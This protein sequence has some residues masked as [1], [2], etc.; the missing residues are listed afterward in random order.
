MPRISQAILDSTFYL[1][2]TEEDAAGGNNFGGTG[3]LVSYECVY[4]VDNGRLNN[5]VAKHHIYA[6][7]NWHVALRSG[8]SVIRINTRDGK[9]KTFPV[10]PIDWSFVPRGDDVAVTPLPVDFSELQCNTIGTHLFETKEY[11]D[12]RVGPGE[13]V[14]MVGRFVDHD[15]GTTNQPAIRFGNISVMPTAMKI[16]ELSRTRDYYCI[17]L[18]SRSG[19][20]GSPVFAYRT[21][22]QDL[23]GND[24]Q[25]LVNKITN[26]EH[27]FS[28]DFSPRLSLLGIHCGQFT[29]EWY[30][31]NRKR[32]SG[33]VKGNGEYIVGMSGMAIV[34]PA[35]TIMEALDLPKFQR[36][37]AE[38]DA[39][40]LASDLESNRDRP[41]LEASGATNH[42]AT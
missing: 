25:K 2:R 16:P 36:E 19:F 31:D 24:I 41:V 6:V 7:T 18:H 10:D 23:E 17:D 1:Y 28:S 34:S 39:E 38:V 12:Y 22:G 27:I 8:C 30:I 42:R 3:F 13:D 40:R 29:E 9:T 4:Q 26:M 11:L 35:W 32:R 5:L 21:F 37:R 14:F 33:K 15:G 20:S